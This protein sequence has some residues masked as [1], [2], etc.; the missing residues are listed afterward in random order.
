MN[1]PE[2]TFTTEQ[3]RLERRLPTYWRVTFDMPLGE[4]LRPEGG[5]SAQRHHHY[6]SRHGSGGQ[7]RRVRQRRRRLLP[8]RITTFSR[9]SKSPQRSRLTRPACQA[10]PDMLV[11]LSRA[12]V[13]S[14]ASIRGRA[15]GVGSEL[16]LWQATCASRAARRLSCRNG[17][18]RRRAGARRRADGAIAAPDGQRPRARS[19]A[20]RR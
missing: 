15:T 19:A 10:L 13:V 11:R 12:P 9:R 8:S 2:R 5:A 18:G 4:H 14:I 20:W 1:R 7:G 16:A 3:I 17:G 6:D